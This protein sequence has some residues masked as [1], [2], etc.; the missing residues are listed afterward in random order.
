MTNS[1][2]KAKQML[3]VYGSEQEAMIQVTQII[4]MSPE[5]KKPY[6]WEVLEKIK[7]LDE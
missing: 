5:D 7:Y 2:V 1:Y 6:W 3:E 4:V